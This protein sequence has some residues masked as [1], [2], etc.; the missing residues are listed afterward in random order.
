MHTRRIGVAGL[1]LCLGLLVGGLA[2]QGA[3]AFPAPARA[4]LLSYA[5]GAGAGLDAG[6]PFRSGTT[7]ALAATQDATTT[8][9]AQDAADTDTIQDENGADDAAEGDTGADTPE[10]EAAEKAAENET[11]GDEAVDGVDCVQEGE[12][13]GENAGC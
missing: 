11:G 4:A 6:L 8:E 5:R 3:A 13:E 10:D 9:G 12:H 1:L 7:T 2:A